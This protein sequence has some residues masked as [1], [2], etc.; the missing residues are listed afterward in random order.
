[1]ILGV[2]PS[3]LL[4]YEGPAAWI[5]DLVLLSLSGF[6]NRIGGV[7]ERIKR[8]RDRRLRPDQRRRLYIG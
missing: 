8:G 2:P 3:I 5:F 7:A 4:G 6:E 1:M